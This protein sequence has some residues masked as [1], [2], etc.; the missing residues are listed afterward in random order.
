[1]VID[2][3]KS[4]A[5]TDTVIWHE[6]QPQAVAFW[7]GRLT[8]SDPHTGQPKQYQ[9]K[10]TG[11]VSNEPAPFPSALLYWGKNVLHF[12]NAFRDVAKVVLWDRGIE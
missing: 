2:G 10:K 7:R 6:I 9:D 12:A 4:P 1:M 3:R 11:R 8:F 5:R